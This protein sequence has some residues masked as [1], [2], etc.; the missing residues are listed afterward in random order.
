MQFFFEKIKTINSLKNY[1]HM[2]TLNH[3][4]FNVS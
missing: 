4:F 3:I 1:K 2:N